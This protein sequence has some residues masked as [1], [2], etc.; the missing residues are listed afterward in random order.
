MQVRE[1][2]QSLSMDEVGVTFSNGT[3]MAFCHCDGTKLE[4]RE[5]FI[6]SVIRILSS[7]ANILK[8]LLGM[9]SEPAANLTLIWESLHHMSPLVTIGAGLCAG[10][11]AGSC[12]L[13][14]AGSN[15]TI[16][17][18]RAFIESAASS[19]DMSSIPVM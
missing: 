15:D 8:S 16:E 3:T 2:G 13:S 14:R 6:M 19:E 1:I 12:V 5:D 7:K 17:V 18:K 4:A 11:K 9:W 10:R